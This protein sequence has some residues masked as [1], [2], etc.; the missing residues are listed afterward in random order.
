MAVLRKAEPDPAL[1]TVAVARAAVERLMAE[2]ATLRELTSGHIARQAVRTERTQVVT[3]GGVEVVE[4]PVEYLEERVVG[5]LEQLQARR[6]L[7]TVEEELLAAAETPE[8]ARV[9]EATAARQRRTAAISVGEIALRR[10][11]P[12]LLRA[13]REAQR[14]AAQ[15][16][17]EIVRLDVQVGDAAYFTN[18]A[19]CPPLMPGQVLDGW[20]GA[21]SRALGLDEPR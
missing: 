18:L 10:R 20:V 7:A 5:K 2:A 3:K 1:P 13:I 12:E 14:L 11:A 16:H 9:H 19:A 15:W 4:V 6:K 21:V 8:L 17:E